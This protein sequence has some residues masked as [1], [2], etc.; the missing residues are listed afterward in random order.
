MY[1]LGEDLKGHDGGDNTEKSLCE[2]IAVCFLCFFYYFI[3]TQLNVGQVSGFMRFH[4][5]YPNDLLHP[6]VSPA[7]SQFC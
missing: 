1:S 5:L 2:D 4:C 7:T 6:P 3:G